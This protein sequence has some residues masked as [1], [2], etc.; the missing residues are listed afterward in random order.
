MS[1]T[2][3]VGLETTQKITVPETQL[4]RQHTIFIEKVEDAS[5]QLG[6]Q[7]ANVLEKN[8]NHVLGFFFR[9]GRLAW[10]IDAPN[11]GDIRRQVKGDVAA[12][13]SFTSDPYE[14]IKIFVFNPLDEELSKKVNGFIKK[15]LTNPHKFFTET[16]INQ[17]TENNP[18]W[19]R[20][21]TVN[22]LSA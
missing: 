18:I 14:N 19:E 21:P 15:S 11:H 13:F 3:I 9:D 5:P 22:Q 1:E 8:S 12:R 17:G 2:P 6:I 20:T 4:A 7:F 10:S 16:N